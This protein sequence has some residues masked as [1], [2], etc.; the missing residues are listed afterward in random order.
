MLI[1][2]CGRGHEVVELARLGFDVTGLDLAPSAICAIE[3]SLQSSALSATLVCDDLFNFQPDAPFD[4][5]YEQTC[6]CAIPPE[7]RKAYVSCLRNW[8]KPKGS[9]FLLMMQTGEASGPPFHCDYLDMHDLFDK[10]H[11][12]WESE[13][14]LVIPRPQASQRFELGFILHHKEGSS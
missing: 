7:Q 14:P 4:A 11:W 2:G 12:E 9:L 3:Q 10:E 13:A 8:L 6:M 1:P 5:V